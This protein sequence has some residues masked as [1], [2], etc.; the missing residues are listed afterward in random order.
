MTGS[1]PIRITNKVIGDWEHTL[2]SDSNEQWQNYRTNRRFGV[3]RVIGHPTRSQWHVV[4]RGV[5]PNSYEWDTCAPIISGPYDDVEAAKA[6]LLV[7]N[8][9]R[10][11]EK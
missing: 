7:I 3:E 6:A 8:S 5:G 1:P 11:S 2:W 9:S 10:G 4:D